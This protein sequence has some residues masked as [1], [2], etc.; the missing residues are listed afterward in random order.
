LFRQPTLPVPDIGFRWADLVHL[1]DWSFLPALML[2]DRPTLQ[3]CV[4]LIPEHDCTTVDTAFLFLSA[5]ILLQRIS[6]PRPFGKSV[7]CHVLLVL[8]I[9]CFVLFEFSMLVFLPRELPQFGN[10][11]FTTLQ[12]N[13]NE[14]P[15]LRGWKTRL[16]VVV[17]KRMLITHIVLHM[18]L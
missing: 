16:N 7:V 3:H 15:K 6:Q 4:S 8:Q 9:Q 14:F 13:K 12:N 1:L 10:S 5:T 18:S 11:K 2:R 17:E